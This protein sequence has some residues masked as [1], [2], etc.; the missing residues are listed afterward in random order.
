MASVS[1]VNTLGV[2]SLVCDIMFDLMKA[3]NWLLKRLQTALPPST[4][5]MHKQT[6][7][8]GK[9]LETV[10][11]G[12]RPRRLLHQFRPNIM[13]CFQMRAL[14]YFFLNISWSMKC[15]INNTLT[16]YMRAVLF[17]HVSN[18]AH[19]F[20]TLTCYSLAFRTCFSV[21][22]YSWIVITTTTILL[23]LLITLNN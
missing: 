19:L 17:S 15:V 16:G 3:S 20:Y 13:V 7:P 6:M 5:F 14:V 22:V 23:L 4:A 11:C 8:Q 9:Q 21:P 2:L 10:D 12:H 18:T 1:L